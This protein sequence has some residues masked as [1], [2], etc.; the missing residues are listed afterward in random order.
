MWL[1][2][3]ESYLGNVNPIGPRACYDE[4]KRVAESLC[5]YFHRMHKTDIRIAR[6]FNT[7]GPKMAVDDGRV[8]SNFICQALK[9]DDLTIYGS[10]KQTRSF[11]YIDDLIDGICGICFYIL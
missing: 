5:V 10:G 2:Q 9:G 11:Q 7:Y 3:K 4:G 1:R 8:V 6:I